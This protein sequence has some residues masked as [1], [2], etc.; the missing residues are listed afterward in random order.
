[1]RMRKYKRRL[2]LVVVIFLLTAVFSGCEN[3][4]VSTPLLPGL[5]I[6][7]SLN[8]NDMDDGSLEH[9][10]QTLQ[11]AQLEVRSLKATSDEPITVNIRGG[12]YYFSESLCF[13]DEDS[14]SEAAPV[15]WQ[16]YNGETVLLSGGIRISTDQAKPVTDD[17]IL[18]RVAD[19]TAREKLMYFDLSGYIAEWPGPIAQD[20]TYEVVSGGPEIYINGAPLTQSR[21]PNDVQNE[22]YLYAD[23]AE[24]L[25][26]EQF[27]PVRLTSKALAERAASWSPDA[28]ENLYVYSFLAADWS[29]GMYDV[30][31]FDAEAGE[32]I[33]AGGCSDPPCESPR[34]YVFNLPEEIDVPGESYIDYENRLIYFYPPDDFDGADICLPILTD[35]IVYLYGAQHL[36][37]RGLNIEYTRGTPF[38]AY[39]VENITIDGCT[40]AHSSRLALALDGA[41]NCTV[42]NCHIYDT[43]EGGIY[44]W[45][46][47]WRN[48]LKPSGNVIEN[49][50]IHGTNRLKKCYPVPI[51]CISMGIIIR[52]NEIHDVNHIAIDISRSNDS[53][54]EYNEIYNTCLETSDVGAIYYGRDPSIMGVTIRYN[55]FH[56]IGNTYGGIGQQAIFCDD[57]ASMPYIYGNLFVNASDANPDTGSAVKAN[58]SQFG[59]VENN[60]FVDVPHAA[61]FGEWNFNYDRQP[62]RQDLWLLNMLGIYDPWEHNVWQSLTGEIDFFSEVWRAHYRGTQW[63]S[64]WTY[65][66]QE[67]REEALRLLHES[68]AADPLDDDSNPAL[69]EWAYRNAPSQTNLLCNNI[70][71]NLGSERLSY[72]DNGREEGNLILDTGIFKD[73][74]GGDFTLT[75]A[76]LSEIRKSIPGFEEVPLSKIGLRPYQAYGREWLPGKST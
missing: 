24:A 53:V 5:N 8:G 64:A 3:Q 32:I 45:D 76:A 18:S 47:E 67:N 30:A 70:C 42:K 69:Y 12:E 9:P 57:G 75:E 25:S 22:A 20:S 60:I 54:I 31:A 51:M 72:G 29:E 38:L 23:S 55:Y 28:W 68:T 17:A 52:N 1:M 50:D 59:V 71:V 66:S 34:F 49:N 7:V 41:N 14:G 48:E 15:T 46:D 10:F 65:I 36:S 62:I 43:A 19:D 37:F 40:L 6:F 4:K 35:A 58:G 27:S 56:D 73:Y 16:A 11:R 61:L 33:T 63:E 26:D 74:A 44:L 39:W 2:A 13:T 21:W